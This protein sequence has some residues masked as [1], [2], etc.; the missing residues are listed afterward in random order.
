MVTR[1]ELKR[2]TIHI[3]VEI[4]P[5]QRLFMPRNVL[6]ITIITIILPLLHYQ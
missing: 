5:F 4:A 6:G 3:L 1:F 2:K